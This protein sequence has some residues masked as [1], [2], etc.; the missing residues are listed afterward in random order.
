MIDPT[1]SPPQ[2]PSDSNPLLFV[3]SEELVRFKNNYYF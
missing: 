3:D 1:Q 2:F